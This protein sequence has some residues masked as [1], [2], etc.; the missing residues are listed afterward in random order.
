MISSLLH[1]HQLTLQPL[2]MTTNTNPFARVAPADGS[3]NIH[4]YLNGQ[5]HAGD[6][7]SSRG[8]LQP[9][10]RAGFRPDRFRRQKRKLTWRF[11][12]RPRRFRL[13]RPFLPFAEPE[14]YFVFGN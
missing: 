4:H 7:T 6:L 10:Q 3:A 1:Y 2:R 8:S 12:R 11:R 14:C 5:L 13:G 9:G